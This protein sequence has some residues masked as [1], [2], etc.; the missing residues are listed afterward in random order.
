MSQGCLQQQHQTFCMPD[1]PSWPPQT[2]PAKGEADCIADK[3]EE[4]QNMTVSSPYAPPHGRHICACEPRCTNFHATHEGCTVHKCVAHCT[5]CSLYQA[6][7]DMYA[8][9]STPTD[10]MQAVAK[11]GETQ[12]EEGKR[13]DLHSCMTHHSR[14]C[15]TKA[16]NNTPCSRHYHNMYRRTCQAQPTTVASGVLLS[17]AVHPRGS[18]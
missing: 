15:S 9:T 2:Q 8:H 16:A 6:L 10:V 3:I 5:C 1:V 4:K 17:V 7:A 14:T 12:T 13:E 11:I 18:A